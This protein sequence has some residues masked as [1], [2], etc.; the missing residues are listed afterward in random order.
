MK[1]VRSENP[2]IRENVE[3][4]IHNMYI[5][6]DNTDRD[7][8]KQ[9]ISDDSWYALK[10]GSGKHYPKVTTALLRGLNN[11]Y[12]ITTQ[13]YYNKQFKGITGRWCYQDI[14]EFKKVIDDDFEEIYRNAKRYEKIIFPVGGIFNSKISNIS[15]ERT[16]ELYDYLMAKCK[17]LLDI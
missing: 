5:F 2:Y 9:L 7:S 4:D 10:Y 16:P 8:G 3:E 12:P 1:V 15:K 13:R 14:E 17:T 11:A 6:T